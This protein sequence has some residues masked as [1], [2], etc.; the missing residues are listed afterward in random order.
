MYDRAS[1]LNSNVFITEREAEEIYLERKRAN[2]AGYDG[3][4]FHRSFDSFKSAVGQTI[5][6]ALMIFALE[7]QGKDPSAQQDAFDIDYDNLHQMRYLQEL[8]AR[9]PSA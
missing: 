7:C 2:P 9:R 1:S 3:N 8:S 4:D 5:G 6:R